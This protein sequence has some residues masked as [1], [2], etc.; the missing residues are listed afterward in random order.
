MEYKA[1][2]M[3]YS[4]IWKKSMYVLLLLTAMLLF[5]PDAVVGRFSLLAFETLLPITAFFMIVVGVGAVFYRN[6]FTQEY[7]LRE[8]SL[9]VIVRPI[10]I[11]DYSFSINFIP[12]FKK[13][14]IVI[15]YKDVEHIE[16]NNTPKISTVEGKYDLRQMYDYV[17]FL[18]QFMYVV[19]NTKSDGKVLVY[20]IDPERQEEF[21]NEI[22]A[23]GVKIIRS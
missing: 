20:Y 14:E 4:M 9:A 2:E 21:V 16:V 19:T 17:P 12:G 3:K 13:W 1:A 18:K 6:H 5:I 11:G 8:D 10:I 23:K 15:P 7:I 22:A